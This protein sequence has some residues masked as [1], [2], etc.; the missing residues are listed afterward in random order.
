MDKPFIISRQWL[1]KKKLILIKVGRISHLCC[2]DHGFSDVSPHPL[3]AFFQLF[4][5]SSFIQRI[6]YFN[7]FIQV[8][9]LDCLPS[10]FK[11]L[12]KLF[13]LRGFLLSLSIY[14]VLNLMF[15]LSLLQPLSALLPRLALSADDSYQYLYSPNTRFKSSSW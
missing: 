8:T 7:P 12:G 6:L 13:L 5:D 14:G 11:D 4:V 10:F 9:G 1:T 15:I 2:Y 3:P